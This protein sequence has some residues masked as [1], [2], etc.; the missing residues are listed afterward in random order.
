MERDLLVMI[1]WCLPWI[2]GDKAHH[3]HDRREV[4]KLLMDGMFTMPEQIQQDE[5]QVARFRRHRFCFKAGKPY[6]LRYQ[7]ENIF[8]ILLCY[9]SS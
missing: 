3:E 2:S 5:L 6:S 1:Y 4:S 7:S 9:T 8:D